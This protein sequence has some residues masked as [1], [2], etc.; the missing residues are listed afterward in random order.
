M[1]MMM[2]MMMMVWRQKLVYFLYHWVYV[3]ND[4]DLN[5]ESNKMFVILLYH[6]VYVKNTT[7]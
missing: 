5:A 2:M 7:C 4:D 6:W 3:K 1:M